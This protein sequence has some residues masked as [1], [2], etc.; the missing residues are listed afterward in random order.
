MVLALARLVTRHPVAVLLVWVV[1]VLL[2]LFPAAKAPQALSAEGSKHSNTESAQVQQLLR[3]R[4]NEKETNMLLL[5]ARSDPPMTGEAGKARYDAFVEALKEV[6]GVG[7]VVA[8]ST[9]GSMPMATA[10]GKLSM[11]PAQ[12]PSGAEANATLKRV[13]EFARAQSRDGLQVQVTG[14]QA[15]QKEVVDLSESD[16]KRSELIALPLI[17]LI[18]LMAFGSL[19]AAG[20]PLVV[21]LTASAL[22]L[23]GIYGVTHFMPVS[24]FAQS[25]ITMLGLGAGIDYALLMVNR[26]R[27][28]LR[29]GHGSTE[30]AR[31]TV[32][33]VGRS[34][35]FSGLTVIIAMIS[36]TITPISIIRGIGIGG[37]LVILLAVLAGLTALPALLTLLGERVNTWGRIP[38][39]HNVSGLSPVWLR[40]GQNLTR[41]PLLPALLAL[42]ALLLLALPMTQMKTGS[43]SLWNLKPGVESREALMSVRELG[44][45]GLLSQVEVVLDLQEG[46]YGPDQR[47]DFQQIV[48]EIRALPGVK[49]VISPFL[50]PEDLR[51]GGSGDGM[52]ALAS[53]NTLAQRSF[54]Q[55]RHLLR[56]T[57]LPDSTLRADRIEPFETQIRGV[58]AKHPYRALL[59]GAAV[60]QREGDEAMNR[61]FGKMIVG[62]LIGTF[63]LLMVAFRSL[64]V[65]LVATLTTSLVIAAALGFIT[66]TSQM[67]IGA[68]LLRFEPDIGIVESAVPIMIFGVMFGLSMDYV[69]FQLS[70]THEEHLRGKT[71]KEAI[72]LGVGHTSRVVLNAAMIMFVVFGAFGLA[73]IVAVKSLGLALALAVMLAATIVNLALLPALLALTGKWNWAIPRWLDKLLPR[74]HLEH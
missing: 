20:L 63:L 27:E 70:R 40:W 55:D 4:F 39:Q 65:P 44:A 41:R 18:L 47:R 67:G 15:I 30:A 13:H 56:F 66:L 36:L 25:I 11:T 22:A 57:V 29:Q 2:C 45:G 61:A 14:N 37:M 6:P 10:D 54:S 69:I 9:G 26:F 43:L 33:T 71:N 64:L 24:T 73:G 12:I 42:G 21:G 8:A 53:L 34:I 49:G 17:A 48:E 32:L 35:L 50:T 52:G 23:A 59:G 16:A 60:E 3:E 62:V 46:R 19:V 38:G 31:R 72:A 5:V 74:I 58:L 68:G 51:G 1:A 28:E 7:T